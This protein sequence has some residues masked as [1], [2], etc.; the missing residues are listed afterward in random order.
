MTPERYIPT[1]PDPFC[2][3]RSELPCRP[4]EDKHKKI[5]TYIQ[6]VFDLFFNQFLFCGHCHVADVTG[7]AGFCFLLFACFCDTVAVPP[8]ILSSIYTKGESLHLQAQGVVF[9]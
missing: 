5:E 3:A 9:H 4:P 8:I 2:R 7:F 1:G 6:I